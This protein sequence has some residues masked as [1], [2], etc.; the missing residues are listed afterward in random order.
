MKIDNKTLVDLYGEYIKLNAASLK[1]DCPSAENLA[2]SFM[3]ST[4]PREKKRI[5]DHIS[6][7]RSCRNA[8]MILLQ[9]QQCE[10]STATDQDN[11]ERK[12]HPKKIFSKLID[13]SPFFRVSGVFV[14]LVLIAISGLL[15]IQNN[16][17][18]R[19]SRSRDTGLNLSYPVMTHP[20]SEKLIFR[21]KRQSES[22]YYV[23]ELFD[24]VL[25]PIWT[26]QK[27]DALQAQLPDDVYT[28]LQIG[29]SYFWLVTGFSEDQKVDESP[30][31][32]FILINRP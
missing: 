5:A 30:L 25:L 26:S 12:G 15:F 16:E 13:I 11:G 23:L 6:H 1:N 32:R 19:I 17:L 3:P 24:E 21:W 9:L 31:A 14:G 2:N 29:K 8:F 10:A 28:N 27:I 4:S 22:G 18:S 7:C 20:K